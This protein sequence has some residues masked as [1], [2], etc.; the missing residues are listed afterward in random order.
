M[1]PAIVLHKYAGS[2]LMS[3]K[4]TRVQMFATYDTE[5]I[6]GLNFVAVKLMT[7]QVIKL[8]AITG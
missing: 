1:M 4:I 6:R 7:V 8:A 3:P 5:N 2:K